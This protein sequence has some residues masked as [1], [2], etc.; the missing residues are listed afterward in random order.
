MLKDNEFKQRMRLG[1]LYDFY[2]GLLTERQKKCIELHFFNDLSLGEIA[3]EQNVSRQAVHDLL[4]R[5]EQ[6]LEKYESQL[7]LLERY[8][9]KK[10]GIIEAEKLLAQYMV[11]NNDK[12]LDKIHMI[13]AR[14]S[15]EGR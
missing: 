13:L 10:K 14:L 7:G 8:E 6:T 2:G 11:T 9:D 12:R 1:R 15:N 3:E 4:K 5:V